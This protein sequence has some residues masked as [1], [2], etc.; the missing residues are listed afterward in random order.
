M[1][2]FSCHKKPYRKSGA[3][4]LSDNLILGLRK[5]DNKDFNQM[6]T[7]SYKRLW[8]IDVALSGLAAG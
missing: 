3:L 6:K 4:F 7:M 1:R 8:A 2:Q 5:E